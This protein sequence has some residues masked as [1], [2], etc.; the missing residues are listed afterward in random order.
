MK[1]RYPLCLLITWLLCLGQLQASAFDQ[2][3]LLLIVLDDLNDY[4]GFLG[5][6]PQTDTPNIDRLAKEGVAFVNAHSNVGVCTP[7]RASFMTGVHPVESGY[8]GFGNWFE[9][10]GLMNCKTLGEL[11][12]ENEYGAYAAGKVLHNYKPYMWTEK[13]VETDYGPL[14]YNGKKTVPHPDSP[15]GLSE[16][17]ALDATFARLSNV[18]TVAPGPDS[19]GYIG[20]MNARWGNPTPFRYVSEDDRDLLFDE[21]TSAWF[22]KRIQEVADDPKSKPFFFGTGFIRPHTPLVV[23]DKY[24]DMFP[25]E[26]IQVPPQLANDLEDTHVNLSSRG[27]KYYQGLVDPDN[28]AQNGLR[29]YIQAYL[30]SVKFADDRVGEVL[31]ALDESPFRENTTVILISDHGYHLGE[32]D[33]VWKYTLW[34]ESTRIPMIIRDPRYSKNAGA[35]V[36]HPVSLVDIY[37]TVQELLGWKG[38]HLKKPGGFVLGG[39][40]L[41]PFLENPVT[42]DWAGPDVALMVAASWKSKKAAKQNLSVRSKDFRYTRY[43]EVGEELYDHR[44]DPNEWH[45]LAD[46][47]AYADIKADLE[48]QMDALAKASPVRVQ[49]SVTP[50]DAKLNADQ[51]WKDNYFKLHLEADTNQDGEL[52]WTEYRAHKSL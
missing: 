14:A 50:T 43:F 16:M 8:W 20:W 31:K 18:P 21:R 42:E 35:R 39:H 2:Q 52:T 27:G 9:E 37:P 36:D 47:P 32:K 38:D 10:A 30:A 19:P 4:V 48:K 5:G 17:G 13:G 12:Q 25:L 41:Q 28:S 1:T 11:A 3:N 26:S 34:D 29:G 45:N 40:S 33:H 23:P 15:K 51:L 6:H 49:A 44:I 7:S 46:D 22:A 24:F